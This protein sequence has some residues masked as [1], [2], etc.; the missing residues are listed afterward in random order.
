MVG[1]F[2]QKFGK[3]GIDVLLSLLGLIFLWPIFQIIALLI[4]L[5]SPGPVFFRQKR[6]GKNGKVF[7]FYKF[8]NMVKEAKNLK[9]KY[10]HLNEADGPVF[11][12]RDDPRYTRVGKFL[13]HTGL[14]EL[15]QLINILKGEM[16][17]V[18]P[19]P[20]PVDEEKQ[21][22]KKWQKRHQ[23]AVKCF[24]GTGI[25]YLVIDQFLVKKE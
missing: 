1:S 21:I 3:R 25:D 22:P 10:F 5:D 15:P 7:T 6:V 18:G 13:S 14:D 2:Y 19:R 9:K 23:D 11:K 16:S 17:L 4:K 12:I 8:R 20:L 24:L